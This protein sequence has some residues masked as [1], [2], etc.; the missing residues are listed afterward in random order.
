MADKI[1]VVLRLVIGRVVSAE[2]M[3]LADERIAD[4]PF[5]VGFVLQKLARSGKLPADE[6]SADNLASFAVPVSGFGRSAPAQEGTHAPAFMSQ[7]VRVQWKWRR[8]PGPLHS[9]VLKVPGYQN[10]AKEPG[11]E[12]QMADFLKEAHTVSATP[13]P[14]PS[15]N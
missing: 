14:P 2:G 9:L 8:E 6:L 11:G 12:E 4:T 5:T 13:P 3:S 15:V 7:I 1:T 10:P